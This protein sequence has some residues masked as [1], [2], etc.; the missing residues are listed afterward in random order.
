MNQ[1]ARVKQFEFK[2]L[3]IELSI[4]LG[5]CGE[6]YLKPT[7]EKEAID[8]VGADSATNVIARFDQYGRSPRLVQRHRTRQPCETGS[9]DDNWSIGEG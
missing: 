6:E 8:L 2:C 5:V 9:N 1:G 7:I 4:E 3:N